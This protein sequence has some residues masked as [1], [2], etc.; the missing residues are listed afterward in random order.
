MPLVC[1]LCQLQHRLKGIKLLTLCPFFWALLQYTLLKSAREGSRWSLLRS[2]QLSDDAHSPRLV[3][4]SL[5]GTRGTSLKAEWAPSMRCMPHWSEEDCVC[6]HVYFPVSLGT[7]PGRL[8]FSGWRN[9]GCLPVSW[10]CLANLQPS[11][12]RVP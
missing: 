11:G 9:P 6:A 4:H 8:Q 10:V 5:G 3:H 12:T 7:L 1:R 2:L